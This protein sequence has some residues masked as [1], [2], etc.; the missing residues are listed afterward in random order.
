MGKGKPLM[1]SSGNDIAIR[2]IAVPCGK[3][4]RGSPRTVNML[5][6][7]H[8][9]VCKSCE[10]INDINNQITMRTRTALDNKSMV[11]DY[12]DD[13]QRQNQ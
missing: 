4:Y 11:S 3:R 6:K 1:K 12:I 9:K 8:K 5:F 2:H 10:N 7:M 13:L